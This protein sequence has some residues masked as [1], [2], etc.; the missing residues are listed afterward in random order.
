MNNPGKC[1][2]SISKLQNRLMEYRSPAELY[3][4]DSPEIA[5]T[6]VKA[7]LG[8]TFLPE[9]FVPVD[10][11]LVLIPIRDAELIP[12]GVYYKTIQGNPILKDFIKIAKEIS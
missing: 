6:L 9:S 10:P 5:V 1:P 8:I 2:F 12:F 3:F 4:C 11:E 7:E